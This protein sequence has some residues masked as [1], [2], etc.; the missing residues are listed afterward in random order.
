MSFQELIK[1]PGLC[2]D[3]SILLRYLTSSKQKVKKFGFNEHL[4]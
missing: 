2:A 1:G 3:V 4:L